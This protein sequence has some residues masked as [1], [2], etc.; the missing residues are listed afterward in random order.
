[1]K[2]LPKI[3]IAAPLYTPPERTFNEDIAKV[4]EPFF[5]VY[6]PQRDGGLLIDHLGKGE[7][8][9]FDHI[10]YKLFHGDLEAIQQV[11]VLLA[12]LDGR[13]IDEG[14]CV[15]IG[16]AYAMKKHCYGLQLDKRRMLNGDNNIMVDHSLL[17]IF[18]TINHLKHWAEHFA[19][20]KYWADRGISV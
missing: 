20:T 7:P 15:E 9:E 17:N 1:M 10:K 13:T 19:V 2:E 12:V 5:K 11:D 4:L 3:Y 18:T 14:V 6:L 16:Y 8:A